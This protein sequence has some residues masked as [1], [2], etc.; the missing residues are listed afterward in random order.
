MGFKKLKGTEFHGSI[1]TLWRKQIYQEAIDELERLEKECGGKEDKAETETETFKANEATK[2]QGFIWKK[3][4]H[5]KI[6]LLVYY[7]S[8]II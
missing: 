8:D 1:E 2:N 4:S 7:I 6:T 3:K 5:D